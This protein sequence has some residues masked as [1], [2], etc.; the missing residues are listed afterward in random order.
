MLS[1]VEVPHLK[2]GQKMK[3]YKRL[4]KAA[5]VGYKDNEK[6]GCLA[7]YIHRTDGEKELAYQASEKT[8]L[9]AAFTFL[10]ELIDGPPCEFL[11]AEEFFAM[12]PNGTSMDAVRSYFFELYEVSKS[13][14][15]PTDVFIKR[16]LSNVLGGKKLYDSNKTRLSIL[17]YNSTPHFLKKYKTGGP[18]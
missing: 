12:K 8:T 11:Q 18:P 10:E 6:L 7:V 15:M 13:A 2:P 5:T 4:F 16:F 3:D 1:T 17:A 9:D 14:K